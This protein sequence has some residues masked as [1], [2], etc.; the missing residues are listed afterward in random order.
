MS[1]KRLRKTWIT[2]MKLEA[3]CWELLKLSGRYTEGLLS[4]FSFVY[5]GVSDAGNRTYGPVHVR[6]VL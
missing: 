5:F 4:C 2:Y 3:M 6:Q 1:C